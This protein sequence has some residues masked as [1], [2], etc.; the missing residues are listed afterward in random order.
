MSFHFP[1]YFKFL[2]KTERAVSSLIGGTGT[3]NIISNCNFSEGLHLWHPI[4]CH[5]YVASQWSGF[6]DGI[7]GNSGENY[8]VVSKRTEFWQGLEQDI[9]DRVSTGTA[10]AVSAYVRVYGNI[11]G[12][13]EVKATLRLQNPDESTH[14]S[15][16]GRYCSLKLFNSQ[17]L[18]LSSLVD[19]IT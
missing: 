12:K 1:N 14:Y 2:Q 17:I 19:D 18:S 11:H 7:R 13:V 10:Y 15:S 5:A 6:L 8:A 4:C 3:A 9:T 16:V